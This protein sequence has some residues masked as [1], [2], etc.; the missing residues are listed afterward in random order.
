[1]QKT[2]V[3]VKPD[4]VQRN[5]VGRIISRFEAANLKLV[6]LK[7]LTIDQELA[8]KHYSE[9]VE[10]PFFP[11]LK[12]YITSGPVVAMILEG[13]EAVEVARKI[14]GATNP[15]DAQAGTIRGDL[16]LTLDYNLVHGSDAPESAQREMDLFFSP[17]ELQD[18]KLHSQ[19][20]A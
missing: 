16:G 10:K 17:A 19:Q 5:L 9:H 1:M 11:K 7:M 2:F 3:M 20:W 13:P 15:F 6:A 4:G 18:Y 12:E 8:A 14:I